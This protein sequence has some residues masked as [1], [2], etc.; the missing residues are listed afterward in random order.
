MRPWALVFDEET[1]I[2]NKEIGTFKASPF[3]PD[4]GLVMGGATAVNL[5]DF[6]ISGID[7]KS[8]PDFFKY[9]DDLYTGAYDIAFPTILVGHNV[10]FDI[11]YLYREDYAKW[12]P[13]VRKGRLWDTMLAEYLLSGQ[14]DLYP[15]LDMCS[16][17]RG[18]TQ[19]PDKIKEYWDAG[20][21]T[22]DIPTDELSEYLVG[23]V[24][25]TAK[26]FVSQLKEAKEKGMLKFILAQMEALKA[27]IEMEWNGMHM[28]RQGLKEEEQRLDREISI[29]SSLLEDSFLIHCINIP[30]PVIKDSLIALPSP[31]SADHVRALLFGG[32]ITLKGKTEMLDKNGQPVRW[33]SG[34]KEGLLRFQTKEHPFIFLGFGEAQTFAAKHNLFTASGKHSVDEEAL[35]KLSAN[36]TN[37]RL[38][39]FIENLL[40]FRGLQKEQTTYVGGYSKLL[41]PTDNCLHPN[42]NM[43]ATATGRLSCSQP[44]LQ[45]ISKK[46]VD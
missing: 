9:L 27:V 42:L 46:E 36:S 38:I 3:H 6:H 12:E 22:S 29:L 31:T 4:N 13:R 25:N 43:V 7:T 39:T 15:N 1:T 19:K 8:G 37:V 26:V 32:K 2:R 24:S 28:D 40:T 5:D 11:L 41:W 33:K 44:N 17:R 18:G 30:D 34:R 23:D 21:D 35:K 10:K 45:N 16:E 14:R 20:I